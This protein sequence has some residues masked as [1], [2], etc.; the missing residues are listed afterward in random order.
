[1]NEIT[2]IE[3]LVAQLRT[4][5]I[6]VAHVVFLKPQVPPYLIYLDDSF[7]QPAANSEKVATVTTIQLELYTKP[8]GTAADEET[9]EA[10]LDTFT[11]YEKSRSHIAEEGVNVTYY[12]FDI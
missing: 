11:T 3:E 7:E 1:M 10:L 6:P 4:L 5:T 8:L 12:T 2:T 9:L